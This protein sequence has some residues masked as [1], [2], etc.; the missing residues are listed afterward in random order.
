MPAEYSFRTRWRIEAPADRCWREIVA[1]ATGGSGAWW[2]RLRV[3]EPTS[4]LEPGARIAAVVRAPFGYALR[5][6]LRITAVE[7]GHAVDADSRG[8]L[9]GRGRVEV[10]ER[11]AGSEIRFAWDVTVRRRW[12]AVASPLL[13]PVFAAGHAVV[14]RAGERGLRRALEGR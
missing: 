1:V 13:R 3:T 14:M 7:A 9:H 10:H 8:D 5:F 2:R 12:M 6:A 11:G 4:R